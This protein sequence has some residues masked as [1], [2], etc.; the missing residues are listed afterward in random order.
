[1]EYLFNKKKGNAAFIF[2]TAI[3]TIITFFIIIFF[4][5]DNVDY[6]ATEKD[7]IACRAIVMGQS[8]TVYK[9]VSEFT[10]DLDLRC[11]KDFIES[12]AIGQEEVFEEVSNSMLRCWQRY[13]SGEEDFLSNFNSDGSWCFTCAKLAFKNDDNAY[14][15]SLG[16]TNFI[17]WLSKQYDEIDGEQVSYLETMQLKY[18]DIDSGRF[19]EISIAID[20]LQS[21]VDQEDP[22]LRPLIYLLSEQN[23][24]LIDLYKKQ[25]YTGEEMYVVYR[26]DRLEK[27]TMETLV[28]VGVGMAAGLATEFVVESVVTFGFGAVPSAVSKVASVIK[29]GKTTLIIKEKLTKAMSLIG[30]S[31]KFSKRT[32]MVASSVDDAM[33]ASIVVRSVDD[34]Y[35]LADNIGDAQDGVSLSNYV[36]TMADDLNKMGIDNMDDVVEHTYDTIDEGKRLVVVTDDIIDEAKRLPDA[37]FDDIRQLERQHEEVAGLLEGTSNV[38]DLNNNVDLKVKIST[39]LKNSA[40]TAGVIVGG[41]VGYNYNDNNRQYVDVMT[42]EQYFRLC[43][44]EPLTVERKGIFG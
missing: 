24:N 33:D 22:A 39:L 5:V 41:Y 15:Y 40:R 37:D 8:S 2:V 9:T 25:I 4:L 27:D 21:L 28:N 11:K 29:A 23:Q 34:L 43:G 42:K 44:A 6:I 13:G 20:E 17:D 36:R 38:N 32:K 19:D 18:S 14:S 10:K 16:E 1:M 26:F 3:T 30:D 7:D 35:D 31:I 12:E